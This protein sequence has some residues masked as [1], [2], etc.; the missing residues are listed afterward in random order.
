M[1][2]ISVKDRLPEEDKWVWVAD[3][4][5]HVGIAAWATFFPITADGLRQEYHGWNFGQDITT[6]VGRIAFWM[7]Q[8]EPPKEDE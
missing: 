8:P 7:P 2:W 6:H 3:K 1:N 4:K 5:G